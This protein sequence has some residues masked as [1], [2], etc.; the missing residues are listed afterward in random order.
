M[1]SK[2]IEDRIEKANQD[3]FT[4]W[5]NMPLPAGRSGLRNIKFSPRRLK[6]R[7]R[8][9]GEVRRAKGKE[10]ELIRSLRDLITCPD[11]TVARNV[12]VGHVIADETQGCTDDLPV[13]IAVGINYYQFRNRHSVCS[14]SADC[15]KWLADPRKPSTWEE[16]GMYSNARSVCNL[17]DQRYRIDACERG[18]HL[19]ITNVFP[20][21]TKLGWGELGLSTYCEMILLRK[22]GF[23]DPVDNLR[24][25]LKD[26]GRDVKL[27]IFHGVNSAVPFYAEDFERRRPNSCPRTVLVNNLSYP[28]PCNNLCIL[29]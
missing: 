22:F 5:L 21:I 15:R 20:W 27:I 13:V 1:T 24:R 29:V 7:G 2:Q 18:F 19:V 25:L 9:T 8:G 28:N 11:R 10:H 4:S 16:S 17:L 12:A 14:L 6:A 3:L 23:S 26:L